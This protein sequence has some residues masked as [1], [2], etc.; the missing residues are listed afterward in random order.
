MVKFVRT[1]EIVE[2]LS[3]FFFFSFELL[4]RFVNSLGRFLIN[5]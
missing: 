4:R 2:C 5:L 3:F 1:I